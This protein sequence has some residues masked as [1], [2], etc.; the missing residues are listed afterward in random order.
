MSWFTRKLTA[1]LLLAT[2]LVSAAA[3][4]WG[5]GWVT[6][7]VEHSDDFLFVASDSASQVADSAVHLGVLSDVQHQLLHEI[8]H[9]P[10]VLTP[11]LIGAFTLPPGALGELPGAVA[12]HP[13]EFAAPFRPPRC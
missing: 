9:Y 1:L 10:P 2:M 4:A 3:F 13:A 6:H 11:S 8:T 12:L 7:E 5:S